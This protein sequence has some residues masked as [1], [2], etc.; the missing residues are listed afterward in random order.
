MDTGGCA[1]TG[2]G[3]LNAKYVLHAVGPMW[4]RNIPALDNV[5]LLAN[6]VMNTLKLA[7]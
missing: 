7:E 5:K 4:N 1:P 3:N 6:A 2:A